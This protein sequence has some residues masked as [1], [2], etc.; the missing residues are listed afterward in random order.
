M[1]FEQFILKIDSLKKS[2]LPGI[3]AH[4][5]LAPLQRALYTKYNIPKNAKKAGVL[6]LF[7][8]DKNNNTAILLT[9]RASYNGKH[10]SQISFPGGKKELTDN[11]LKETALRETYEEIGV[12]NISVIK[13][14]TTI[15][16]PPSNFSVNPYIGVVSSTPTFLPNY[17]VDEIIELP[18]SHLLKP[19]TLSYI[20]TKNNDNVNVNIPCFKFNGHYIWGATAM[21]LNEIKELLKS[22]F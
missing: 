9:K 1:E 3:S 12:K 20:P 18:V 5:V 15:Y 13:Q 14:A 7:Y 4:K 19:E 17:E 10:S 6:V 2:N 16:I 22:L 11:T 21:M 8:P